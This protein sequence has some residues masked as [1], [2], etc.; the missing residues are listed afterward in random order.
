MPPKHMVFIALFS[1]YT[2]LYAAN[3]KEGFVRKLQRCLISMETWCE[4][5]NNNINEDETLGIY[6]FRR[7]DSLSPI[8]HWTDEVFRL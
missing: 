5:W 6:F 2:C 3:R 4:L 7:V 1:D 8:L